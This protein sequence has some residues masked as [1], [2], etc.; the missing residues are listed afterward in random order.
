MMSSRL[1]SRR[2][3]NLKILTL[4]ILVLMVMETCVA[5]SFSSS[6]GR[7]VWV[8]IYRIQKIDEVEGPLE[9]EADWAYEISVSY[10][11]D[12]LSL[13]DKA[14]PNS[15]DI[16]IDR[17]YHF[18]ISGLTHT[19]IFIHLWEEDGVVVE[20]A[21][22]S[23]HENDYV[24][25]CTYIFSLHDLDAVQSDTFVRDGDFYKTSGDYDGSIEIDENDANLWFKVWDT[26]IVDNVPPKIAISSPENKVYTTDS[27]ALSFNV[28]EPTVW[29]GYSLDD[30]ANVTITGNTTL[31]DLPDGAHSIT[32]YARDTS[33]NIGTSDTVY[34]AVS[35]PSPSPTPTPTP[36][37][38]P[39]PAP[40]PS[41]TPTPT[42]SPSPT[43]APS[44][45]PIPTPTPTPTPSPFPTPTFA[46]T[47]APTS[48][49][50]PSP[51]PPSTPETPQIPL[52]FILAM[53][54]LVLTLLAVAI[55]YIYRKKK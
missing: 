34:F 33:G 28:N 42:P 24:F 10:G 29:M 44:P 9:G 38:S 7:S 8:K 37:P 12:V 35:T 55:I 17:D 30:K 40:S 22:I 53:L 45:S 6:D 1:P 43:P 3:L 54:V 21:D 32:V 18:D 52:A 26:P 2:L 25:T 36:S 48:P 19:T 20:N 31:A 4:A 46:P 14:P 50:S 16:I 13:G 51:T 15:D 23:S 27:I 47:P 49:P 41:P 5:T 11:E 39:T